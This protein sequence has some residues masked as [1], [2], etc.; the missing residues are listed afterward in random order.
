LETLLLAPGKPLYSENTFLLSWTSSSLTKNH[1]TFLGH[2]EHPSNLTQ[3]S[4]LR[5]DLLTL[6]GGVTF[7]CAGFLY[8]D[9]HPVEWQ[10]LY[11]T[12]VIAHYTTTGLCSHW[13]WVHEHYLFSDYYTGALRLHNN[14]LCKPPLPMPMIAPGT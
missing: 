13:L 7:S 5:E 2:Q 9:C 8:Y 14:V 11:T 3:M 4:L 10:S 1:I 6:S 12:T